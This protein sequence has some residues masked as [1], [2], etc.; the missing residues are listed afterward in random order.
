MNEPLAKHKIIIEADDNDLIKPCK[1]FIRDLENEY[2]NF[3]KE[4]NKNIEKWNKVG[5]LNH[6]NIIFTPEDISIK[7]PLTIIDAPWG[8]GKTFLL[9]V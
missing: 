8:A 1:K 9:K 7:S 3:E 5:Y 4:L 2:S 6:P